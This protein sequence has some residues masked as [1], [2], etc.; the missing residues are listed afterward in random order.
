MKIERSKQALDEMK[1]RNTYQNNDKKG[2]RTK[3]TI[4][5]G[6]TNDHMNPDLVDNQQLEINFIYYLN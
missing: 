2:T 3:I 4:R 5:I 6:S 1:E